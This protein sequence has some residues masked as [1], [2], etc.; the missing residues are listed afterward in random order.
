MVYEEIEKMT[1]YQLK[2]FERLILTPI[3]I[4]TIIYPIY[5][6]IHGEIFNAVLFLFFGFLIGIIGAS[7]HKKLKAEQLFKGEHWKNDN[8]Q[9]DY[10]PMGI[11]KFNMTPELSNLIVK[12]NGLLFVFSLIFL[13]H[14]GYD[15]FLIIILKVIVFTISVFILEIIIS[16]L[17]PGIIIKFKNR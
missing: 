2:F 14:L 15:S 11:E 7:L 17:I 4:L 16:V 5:F 3:N 13:I 10:I 12:L 9:I 1:R 8:K 6:L